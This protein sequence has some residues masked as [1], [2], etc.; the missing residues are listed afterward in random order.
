MINLA[1][2]IPAEKLRTVNVTD[3]GVVGALPGS[4][5]NN[6]CN[7]I[8]SRMPFE[9]TKSLPRQIVSCHFAQKLHRQL[10]MIGHGSTDVGFAPTHLLL[11]NGGDHVDKNA[12][13][14]GSGSY[15]MCICI[16]WAGTER[17]EGRNADDPGR[18]FVGRRG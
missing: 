10:A 7:S 9:R 1:E 14:N 12:P 11:R 2:E 3:G 8:T 17:G 18:S 5:C 13:L 15:D 4:S 16:N 6:N